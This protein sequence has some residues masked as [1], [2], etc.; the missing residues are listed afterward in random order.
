MKGRL[1]QLCDSFLLCIAIRQKPVDNT[2]DVNI[3]VLGVNVSFYSLA[4]S[5][6]INTIE[7]KWVFEQSC[8]LAH[9][10]VGLSVCRSVCRSVWWVNCGKTADWIWM[11][12]RMVSWVGRG[13]GVLDGWRSSKGMG[14]F[15]GKC[16]HPVVTS[17]DFV[18]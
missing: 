7:R 2:Q 13:I 12:F 3:C 8:C 5:L 6:S 15:D 11:P 17:G 14:S 18:A 9:L 1:V 16:G 10:H 4:A